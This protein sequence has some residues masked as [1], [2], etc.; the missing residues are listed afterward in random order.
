M[1]PSGSGWPLR[2]PELA[3]RFS[4]ARC[5]DRVIPAVE[6]GDS[7]ETCS[8][9]L[10]MLQVPSTH[11]IVRRSSTDE[12][13][14]ADH[15]ACSTARRSSQ[16]S[17]FP[18]ST[19]LLPFWT[20]T[21]IAFASTSACLLSADSILLFTFEESTPGLMAILF[22][23]PRSPER[24]DF[25]AVSIRRPRRR[26]HWQIRM[27]PSPLCFGLKIT[28][29]D[30]PEPFLVVRKRTGHGW[31]SFGSCGQIALRKHRSGRRQD[32]HPKHP[33]IGIPV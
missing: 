16:L 33:R 26:R 19:A 4:V 28:Q 18:S 8:S 1:P 9:Q 17:T 29:V 12:T 24:Q 2:P 14:A 21:R 30:D 15:A 23:T 6:R 22:V 31:L 5:S 11:A 13:P 27:A 25:P 10:R 20:V 7:R 32:W 3:I